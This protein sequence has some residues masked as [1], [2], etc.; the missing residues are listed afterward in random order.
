[1]TYHQEEK[2]NYI[3]IHPSWAHIGRHFICKIL[4]H[5]PFTW[6][7]M[8]QSYWIHLFQ[9]NRKLFFLTYNL[10]INNQ[11]L[12]ETTFK[13]ISI[14]HHLNIVL[15]CGTQIKIPSQAPLRDFSGKQP[16]WLLR[17]TIIH[18]QSQ[19]CFRIMAGQTWL[20]V[21]WTGINLIHLFLQVQTI[22]TLKKQVPFLVHDLP[23]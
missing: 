12:N 20:N 22:D 3:L 7:V 5:C 6:Y 11:H 4:R 18:H 1:M 16:G 19:T 2:Q 14:D 13:S 10:K 23:Y 21:M 15:L 9:A 17:G 8:E